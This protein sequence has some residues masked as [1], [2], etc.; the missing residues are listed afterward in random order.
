MNKDNKN[1]GFSLVELI[2]A[3]AV[4][5]FLMLAVSSFMGSSVSQTR[6]EQVDVKLQTQA[7][8]TYSLITDTIM[9]A[10]DIVMVGYT[11]SEQLNFAT[12]G[13]ETSATMAKKFYVKDEATAKALV[14]DPSLYG[15]TDS[16]SKA[17]VIC[18]KDIDVD[19][20]IYISY[21]RI[22]SS[23]PLDMNLVPGGNPSILSE[24]VITNSL[25][26]EATK[27]QCTEQ[28]SKIVYSINDTLVSTFYF[29]N[30]N[31][32]YGRKY[33]YMTMSDDEVDMSDSNSKFVHL[34]NPYLSYVEAKLGAIGVGVTGCTANI[35]AKNNS[36]KLDIY[37]NQ[38]NM[39][40]TTNGRVNPRNSYVLVP[41]K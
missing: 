39:T 37:Y 7:Q 12:V 28:N 19:D 34:Y 18:F 2:I 40:Y 21:L 3:I 30:N 16:V 11:A 8:E 41:K 33:A 4:L 25:T 14:K 32:Y 38:S 10:N 26:G 1:S 23:V 36:V 35:D 31:M 24:Q 17:D 13:E 20:P 6:K 5:A 22:E 9:Q 27:V 29:E 15:I